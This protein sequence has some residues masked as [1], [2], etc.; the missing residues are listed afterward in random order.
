MKQI[1]KLLSI[2]L[3]L[4]MGTQTAYSQ[5]AVR[6]SMGRK[7]FVAYEN[8]KIAVTMTNHAGRQIDFVNKQGVPW[9]DLIVE[10]TSGNPIHSVHNVHYKPTRLKTGETKTSNFSLNNKYDLSQPGNYVAYAV[11]R[12]PGQRVQEGVRTR[13]VH[14]TV[15]RGNPLWKQKAGVP[16]APGDSR[17]FRILNVKT[18]EATQLY[19]QVED[20][21]RKKMLA[22]YTMGRNLSFRDFTATLDNR[23]RMHVLFLTNPTIWSHT[24]VDAAGKTVRRN[25]HKKGPGGSIPKLITTGNGTV[26]VINSSFFDPEKESDIR[27]KLHNLSELPIGL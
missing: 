9:I 24:V 6:A 5:I 23:N 4:V 20:T 7:E 19:V 27:S 14:F 18:D 2:T 13:K 12:M 17:E 25:Y 11:V 1:L 26:G 3:L 10:R 15:I 22:T 8:V 21:K 16:G